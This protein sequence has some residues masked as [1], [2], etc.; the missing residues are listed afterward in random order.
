MEKGIQGYVPLGGE[1]AVDDCAGVAVFL[2]SRLARYITGVTISI[3]GGT[4]ASSGW[5]RRATG[6]WQL[7]SGQQDVLA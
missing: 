5:S 6:G 7:F 2:S 1:G 4:W 3:D